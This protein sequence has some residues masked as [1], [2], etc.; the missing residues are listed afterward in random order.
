[1]GQ[2]S[3]INSMAAHGSFHENPHDPK[4]RVVELE[5]QV[6]ALVEALEFCAGKPHITDAHDV[7]IAAL[8]ALGEVK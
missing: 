1:M 3:M 5:K 8:A 2:Y 4:D 7:A 6:K